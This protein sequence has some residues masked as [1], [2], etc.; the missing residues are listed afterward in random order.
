MNFGGGHEESSD[1]ERGV[2]EDSEDEPEYELG[3][4]KADADA[5]YLLAGSEVDEPIDQISVVKY[6]QL[7]LNDHVHQAILEVLEEKQIQFKLADFQMI[8]EGLHKILSL[9]LN[10][11]EKRTI[12][13]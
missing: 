12:Y 10:I 4:S 7:M 8:R 3:I 9:G 11:P 1:E 2:L 6:Q 5:N 13:I